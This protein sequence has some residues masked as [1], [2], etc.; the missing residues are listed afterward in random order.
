MISLVEF[1][2]PLRKSGM[3]DNCLAVLYYQEQYQSVVSLTVDSLRAALRAAHVK[4]AARANIA[5]TLAK[6][7][8]FV[9][10]V[11]EDTGRFLWALTDS[12]KT[13]VQQL[14]KL[15]TVPPQVEQDVSDLEVLLKKITDADVH[16]YVDEALKCLRVGALRATVVFLWAAAIRRVQERCIALGAGTLNPALQKHD[17][18]ARNV[19]KID[20]FAHVKEKIVILA[21]EDL[22][23]FDKNQRSVLEDCLD[24]RNRCGHPSKYSPGS[25]KVGAF[26]EDILNLVF[27]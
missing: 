16:S 25:K 26:L 22:G 17:P 9:R 23:L 11:G 19:S 21:T 24:L 12:G 5:D 2:Y 13:Y 20:D 6:S 10:T 4:N 27:K 8:P 18:K 14:L 15:P 3:R 1:I 7:A